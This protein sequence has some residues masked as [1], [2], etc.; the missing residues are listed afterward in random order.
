MTTQRTGQS[1]VSWRYGVRNPDRKQKTEDK[2]MTVQSKQWKI[3]ADKRKKK[4][5]REDQG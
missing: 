4:V 5:K 3:S 1:G 2:P